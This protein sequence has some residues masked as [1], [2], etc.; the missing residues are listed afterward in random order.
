LAAVQLHAHIR[1]VGRTRR[2]AL[3]GCPPREAVLHRQVRRKRVQRGVLQKPLRLELPVAAPL[4]AGKQCAVAYP[5]LRRDHIDLHRAVPRLHDDLRR[6]VARDGLV[7]L[8]ALGVEA[9]AELPRLRLALRLEP[10]RRQPRQRQFATQPVG[11]ARQVE[12]VQVARE[13]EARGLVGRFGQLHCARCNQ[14][15][16]AAQDLRLRDAQF[17]LHKVQVHDG[18]F[19]TEVAHAP[20][21]HDCLGDRFG[22]LEA[23]AQL[24]R[25]VANRRP[26]AAICPCRWRRPA[27][28]PAGSGQPRWRPR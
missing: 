4:P 6:V 2:L 26:V 20:I 24:R 22:R 28:A 16:C 21:E 14:L 10:A 1:R 17:A 15:C 12:L 18:D 8:Q 3:H 7:V 5:R 11:H 13:L 23:A 19:R 9:R 25:E 27:V